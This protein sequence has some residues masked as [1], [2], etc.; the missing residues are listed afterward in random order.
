MLRRET[1]RVSC[2]SKSFWA[3][4]PPKKQRI[5]LS[6]STEGGQKNTKKSISG[7]RSSCYRSPNFPYSCC[8]FNR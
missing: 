7:K 1:N 8:H 4:R 3:H 5:I 2:A 6:A